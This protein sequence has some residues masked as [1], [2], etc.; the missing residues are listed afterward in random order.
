MNK[1]IKLEEK[2]QPNKIYIDETY[3]ENNPLWHIEDS[4]WKATQIIKIIS[5]H[6]I[7]HNEIC[8]V[9]CGGGEILRQLSLKYPSTRLTGYELSPHAF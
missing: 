5:K 9:G 7:T 2:F 1:T 3:L 6:N 8:E 4:T